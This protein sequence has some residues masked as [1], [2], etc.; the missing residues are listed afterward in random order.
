MPDEKQLNAR[1]MNKLMPDVNAVKPLTS[2]DLAVLE[3]IRQVLAKHD[4]LHRFGVMLQHQHFDMADDEI[5][6]ES[7]DVVNRVQTTRPMKRSP[8]TPAIETA[9]IF[10]S[11][12]EGAKAAISC[13]LACYVGSGGLHY[14]QHPQW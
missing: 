3:E 5:M 8:E 11:N 9:W 2:D 6:V 1:P 7:T 14:I 12:E 4:A 13:Y 10:G